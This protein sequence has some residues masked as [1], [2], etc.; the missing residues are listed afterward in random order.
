MT[1]AKESLG[2]PGLRSLL[3]RPIDPGFFDDLGNV[4]KGADFGVNF[5]NGVIPNFK[6]TVT[7]FEFSHEIDG[8]TGEEFF[9][10]FVVG[11][12]VLFNGAQVI[13]SVVMD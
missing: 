10:V 1:G 6:A 5:Y 8:A 4:G 12:L 2:D 7:A 11:V 13:S 3:H 9:G